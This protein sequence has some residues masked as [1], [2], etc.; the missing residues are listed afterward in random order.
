MR[1][2]ERIV[3]KMACT[4]FELLPDVDYKNPEGRKVVFILLCVLNIYFRL[5]LCR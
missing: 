4:L 3:R 5:T 1:Y 2:Q